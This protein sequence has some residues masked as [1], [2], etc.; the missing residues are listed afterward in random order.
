MEFCWRKERK[1]NAGKTMMSVT[2]VTFLKG[3][4]RIG[5]IICRVQCK[6]RIQDS[7]FKIKNF[8]IET[9]KH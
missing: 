9:V 1:M 2:N 5:C 4:K 6:M 8:K 7:L 3:L